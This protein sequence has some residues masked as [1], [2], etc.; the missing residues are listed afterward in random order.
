MLVYRNS[1]SSSE[2]R[3]RCPRV[4]RR[5]DNHRESLVGLF[6]DAPTIDI[7]EVEFLR[8][9]GL[10]DV[11]G[12]IDTNVVEKSEDLPS[13]FVNVGSYSFQGAARKL[14]DIGESE[15]DEYEIT[16]ILARTVP[17]F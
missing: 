4:L 11:D 2:T 16:D 3:L 7:H 8:S 6:H 17:D 10:F 9:Y 13:K 1:C 12:G 14:L 15:R 5:R